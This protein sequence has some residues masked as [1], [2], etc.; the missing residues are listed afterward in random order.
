MN[1]YRE[2]NDLRRPLE[3]I[4]GQ[5][6]HPAC[7]ENGARSQPNTASTGVYRLGLTPFSQ[8]TDSEYL[9]H[10]LSKE[11]ATDED[12]ESALRIEH[13]LHVKEGLHAQIALLRGKL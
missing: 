3:T 5:P 4:V 11:D 13:L 7:A 9:S 2:S 12:I 6:S 1:S 10:L 8:M